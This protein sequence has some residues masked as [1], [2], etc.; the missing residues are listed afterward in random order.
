MSPSRLVKRKQY[1][2]AINRGP[3]AR[4]AVVRQTDRQRALPL[5]DTAPQGTRSP[6]RAAHVAERQA[7]RRVTGP[8]AGAWVPCTDLCH[9]QR[10]R[11]VLLDR[12]GRLIAAGLGWPVRGF[13]F[14][15]PRPLLS[16]SHGRLAVIRLQRTSEPGW[17]CCP[18][19]QPR[20]TGNHCTCPHLPR[21]E[22]EPA[23]TPSATRLPYAPA[24]GFTLKR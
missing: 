23:R 11:V 10:L 21:I 1:G 5:A 24:C 19:G 13:Y 12:R 4:L 6:P 8:V 9:D 20:S 22:P 14:Y 16:L 2:V 3:V 18:S 15:P 17:T 7:L